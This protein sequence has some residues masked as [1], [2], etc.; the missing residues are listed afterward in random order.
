MILATITSMSTAPDATDA[1]DGMLRKQC[2]DSVEK[3]KET[4]GGRKILK[5]FF[6]LYISRASL[7]VACW[8][9]G[10]F[11]CVASPF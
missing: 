5:Y 8:H 4:E 3:E 9:G 2:S 1:T 7:G 6:P 10:E 11:G